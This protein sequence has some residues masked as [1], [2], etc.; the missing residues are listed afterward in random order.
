MA[1]HVVAVYAGYGVHFFYG[2]FQTALFLIVDDCGCFFEAAVCH[3][4]LCTLHGVDAE[5]R[6]AYRVLARFDDPIDIVLRVNKKEENA[7][8][9]I[10]QTFGND[11]YPLKSSDSSY[12]RILVT[13]SP[14]FIKNWALLHLRDVIVE[15]ESVREQILEDLSKLNDAYSPT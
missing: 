12:D 6:D 2:Q 15:T 1:G 11:F 9:L 5:Q 4:L 3:G 10:Y 13:R 7:Y 14:F 8:T